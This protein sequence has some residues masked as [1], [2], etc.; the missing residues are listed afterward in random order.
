MSLKIDK[1]TE[2]TTSLE[3][4]IENIIKAKFRLLDDIQDQ[5]VFDQKYLRIS[6]KKLD[7]ESDL[8]KK[9]LKEFNDTQKELDDQS[10]SRRAT[11][12]SN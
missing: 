3:D 6:F 4:K 2:S 9:C 12:K 8:L 11:K 7:R 1:N 10:N 5:N